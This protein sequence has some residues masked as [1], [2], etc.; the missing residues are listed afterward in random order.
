MVAA[1]QAGRRRGRA[2]VDRVVV[3]GAI[4]DRPE[5]GRAFDALAEMPAFAITSNGWVSLFIAQRA[6]KPR[7]MLDTAKLAIIVG[8]GSRSFS[9]SCSAS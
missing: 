3:S 9:V 5:R 1:G 7:P 8:P 2:V 6:F 4:T